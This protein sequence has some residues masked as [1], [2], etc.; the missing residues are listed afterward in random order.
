M[1]KKV[2][3]EW[4]FSTINLIKN[5]KMGIGVIGNMIDNKREEFDYLFA[6]SKKLRYNATKEEVEFALF[7]EQNNIPYK[8]QVPIKGEIGAYI[9]DFIIRDNVIVEIDGGYHSDLKQIKKDIRR[10]ADLYSM[11]YKVVRLKNE[12]IGCDDLMGYIDYQMN[13]EVD[14]DSYKRT[15]EK[16]KNGMNIEL[17]EC[18]Y[19]VEEVA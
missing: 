19:C 1:N 14:V 6:N 3:D 16:F 10:D 12:D 2:I 13:L 15:V 9:V 11:G 4:K 7:L 18:F 5:A 8:I 17:S